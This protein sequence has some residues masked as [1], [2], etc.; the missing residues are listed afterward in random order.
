[1]KALSLREINSAEMS[2]NI[3]G[4]TVYMKV[5]SYNSFNASTTENSYALLQSVEDKT[6]HN[7]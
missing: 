4:T 5:V 6:S 1:M 7:S 3:M 2:S